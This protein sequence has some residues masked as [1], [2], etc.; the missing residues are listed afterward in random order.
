M[1]RTSRL[2][3]AIFVLTTSALLVSCVQSAPTESPLLLSPL[4]SP[5]LP[6]EPSTSS[7]P[8]GP[9]FTLDRPLRAGSTVVTGEGPPGVPIKIVNITR[10]GRE[11]GTG[12][13]GPNGH[14]T[15]V[16]S[17]LPA[18]EHIGIMLGNVAGTEFKPEDFLQGEGYVDIPMIGILFD[19]AMV[20]EPSQ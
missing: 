15:V 18:G 3:Y 17:P 5:L 1:G 6:P 20:E 10:V 7:L 11:L 12:V 8:I 16:V 9:R 4:S 14:F 19:T 2:I 13:I